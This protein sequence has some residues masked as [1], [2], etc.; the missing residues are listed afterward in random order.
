MGPILNA[1]KMMLFGGLSLGLPRFGLSVSL[2]LSV[3]F[4][5]YLTMS[6]PVGIIVQHPQEAKGMKN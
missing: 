6:S 2:V 4:W 3:G 1:S 5:V